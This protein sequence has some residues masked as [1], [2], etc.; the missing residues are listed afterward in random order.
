MNAV[1]QDAFVAAEKPRGPQ[2]LK[3]HSQRLRTYELSRQAKQLRAEGLSKTEIQ[4]ALNLGNSTL[5]HYLKKD[6][7]EPKAE[8]N[9]KWAE[10]QEAR[11]WF[12]SDDHEWPF[13]FVSICHCLDLNPEYLRRLLRQCDWQLKGE[14]R[15]NMAA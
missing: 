10:C 11:E 8:P 9:P 1:L 2:Y 6:F 12:L 4:K 15:D 7:P 13:S 3:I 14:F 5:D